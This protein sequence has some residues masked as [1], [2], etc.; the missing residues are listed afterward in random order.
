MANV[1][2]IDD[3]RTFVFP[4]TYARTVADG[5][6]LLN[7]QEW[8]Q[9]WL[10]YDMGATGSAHDIATQLQFAPIVGEYVI[11]TA[12]PVGRADLAAALEDAG[13][14]YRHVNAADFVKRPRA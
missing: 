6:R 7:S 11:H 14:P 3:Q 5:L 9:V 13:L 4:A 12:N 8:N 10:D 1:L 2:V